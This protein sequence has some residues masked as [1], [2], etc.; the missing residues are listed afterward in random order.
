MLKRVAFQG[1]HGSFAEE[2]AEEFFAGNCEIIACPELTDM[3]KVLETEAADYAVLPVE[4]SLIG[5]VQVTNNFLSLNS[6][7]E[8]GELYLP[9]RLN[10]IGCQ[11][12]TLESLI[13]V[14]SHPA[15]LA[16]CQ[17]F[18]FANPHLQK[19]PTEN[20]AA[21]ARRVIESSDPVQAAIAS[22]KAA[23]LFG[24]KILISDIQ[25]RHE[26]FTRFLLLRK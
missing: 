8:V 12:A 17:N 21:S 1:E 19:I 22:M 10:L 15:A 14:E 3:Q 5:K 20:T 11:T 26:N 25:D 6:W 9:I 24:G 2:A 23:E 18:F 16:Q 13:T 4:N 7:R